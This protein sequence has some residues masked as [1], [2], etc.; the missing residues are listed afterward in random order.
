[1]A[2][3]NPLL[4]TRLHFQAGCVIKAVPGRLTLVHK[5]AFDSPDRTCC[6]RS[7]RQRCALQVS[8]ASAEM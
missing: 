6:C 3:S 2:H 7:R 8:R 5:A 4:S 1:M